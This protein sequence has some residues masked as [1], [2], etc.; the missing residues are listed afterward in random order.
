MTLRILPHSLACSMSGHP[1]LYTNVSVC[2]MI[3]ISDDQIGF[4][5]GMQIG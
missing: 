1:D 2:V 3:V 5:S 4:I